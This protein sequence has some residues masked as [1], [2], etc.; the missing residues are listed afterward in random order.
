MNWIF[1]PILGLGMESLWSRMYETFGEDPL[2]V[3]EMGKAIV[4]GIQEVG[5]DS[6]SSI[7]S[8]SAACAKH[9]VGYS[10]PRTGHDR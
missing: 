1:S 4:K 8:R 5:N 7:P 10:A 9:F 2:L 6:S 3:G